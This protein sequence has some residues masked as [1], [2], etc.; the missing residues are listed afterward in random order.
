MK[1]T[2]SNKQRQPSFKATRIVAG[3]TYWSSKK[4]AA[5]LGV[6][7]MCLH[8]H[9]KRHRLKRLMLGGIVLYSQESLDNLINNATEIGVA[10]RKK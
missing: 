7:R 1:Q 4:A 6:T 8:N 10:T 2:Q 3:K 5:Y 9:V